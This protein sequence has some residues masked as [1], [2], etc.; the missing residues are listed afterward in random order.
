MVLLARTSA[1]PYWRYLI[2][3]GFIGEFNRL[4]NSTAADDWNSLVE[5]LKLLAGKSAQAMTRSAAERG[6][7]RFSASLHRSIDERIR[8]LSKPIAN[9]EQRIANLRQTVSQ[10]EQSL[11]D[12]GTLFSAEQMR[13]F[14]TLLG[15]RKEFLKAGVANRPPKV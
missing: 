6:V 10:T 14:I 12:L 5:N 8:A 7:H 1:S 2:P 15:R 11:R 3:L 4:N 13:L 9:S